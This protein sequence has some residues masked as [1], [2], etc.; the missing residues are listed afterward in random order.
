LP[1]IAN[2]ISLLL[3]KPQAAQAQN[4]NTIIKL[5]DL[6]CK[7]L[8]GKY[9]LVFKMLIHGSNY[10]R[11]VAILLQNGFDCKIKQKFVDPSGRYIGIK[12][13]I[14]DENYYPFNVYS[15]NNDNHAAQFYDH[16]L[17]MLQKEDLAYEDKIIIG[18]DFNCPLNPILDKQGVC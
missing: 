7:T 15:P 11:G 8:Y 9:T 1:T 17:A 5:Y 4:E 18:G 6:R 3:T 16:L 13:Q 10:A 14:N 2:Y 12:A